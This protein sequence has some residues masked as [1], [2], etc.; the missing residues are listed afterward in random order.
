MNNSALII[1]Y[2]KE[3]LKMTFKKLNTLI[4]SHKQNIRPN[5][6]Y[7]PSSSRLIDGNL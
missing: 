1:I 5:R 2:L 3:I 7:I 4:T 6:N